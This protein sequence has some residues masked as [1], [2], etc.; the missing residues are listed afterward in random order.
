MPD[1]TA[2]VWTTPVG[3]F[4]AHTLPTISAHANLFSCA[5]VRSGIMVPKFAVVVRA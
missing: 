2:S 3:V 4:H 1:F 5:R